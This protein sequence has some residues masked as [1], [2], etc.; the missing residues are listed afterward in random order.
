VTF[1]ECDEP[2]RNEALEILH[3]LCGRFE[4]HYG[5]RIVPVASEAGVHRRGQ[6][7]HI[8]IGHICGI[9]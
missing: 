4:E 5:I 8:D 2:T 1:E 6:F 7:F 3:G 9:L